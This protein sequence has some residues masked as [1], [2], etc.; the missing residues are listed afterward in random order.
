MHYAKAY[1]RSTQMIKHNYLTNN[2]YVNNSI[3]V[4]SLKDALQK[5]KIDY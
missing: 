3:G 2:Y 1:I 4:F 5:V